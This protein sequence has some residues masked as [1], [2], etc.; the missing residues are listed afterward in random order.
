[1]YDN[2]LSL[3]DVPAD[4]P[5]VVPARKK[6]DPTY[7]LA[8]YDK[9]Q[10]RRDGWYRASNEDNAVKQLKKNYGR[11]VGVISVSLSSRTLEE[12]EAAI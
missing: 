7:H 11:Q 8:F 4:S 3:F 5:D 6:P 9:D 12:V 10:R 2:Q 1:M